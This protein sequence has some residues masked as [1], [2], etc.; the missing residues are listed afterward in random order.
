MYVLRVCATPHPHIGAASTLIVTANMVLWG[1]YS[2]THICMR[3]RY[4][5][6]FRFGVSSGKLLYWD[7]LLSLL[8]VTQTQFVFR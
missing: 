6:L 7:N 2:H 5:G 8:F 1:A 3:G 4:V